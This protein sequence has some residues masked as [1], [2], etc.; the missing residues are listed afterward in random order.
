MRCDNLR[1]GSSISTYARYLERHPSSSNRFKKPCPCLFYASLVPLH[2]GNLEQPQ[3]SLEYLGEYLLI[4]L[5]LHFGQLGDEGDELD[6]VFLAEL[7]F[8]FLPLHELQI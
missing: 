7:V 3:N 6:I 8:L 2:D 4:I 1:I 5:A